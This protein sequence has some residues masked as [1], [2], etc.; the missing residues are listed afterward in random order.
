[1]MNDDLIQFAAEKLELEI[2][3]CEK[4]I[5]NPTGWKY[6]TH[7]PIE[8]G[9]SSPVENCFD[10]CTW[11]WMGRGMEQLMCM[12]WYFLINPVRVQFSPVEE[13]TIEVFHRDTMSIPQAFWQCWMALEV[14]VS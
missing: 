10:P 6:I 1:M 2:Q 3:Q 5:W 11:E 14:N 4:T 9:R 12:G 8:E 13:V 7:I